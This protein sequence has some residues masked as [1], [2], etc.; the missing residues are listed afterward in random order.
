MIL[1]GWRIKL[2]IKENIV[3]NVIV[4]AKI[5]DTCLDRA[6]TAYAERA[7]TAEEKHYQ[8]SLYGKQKMVKDAGIIKQCVHLVGKTGS[9][10]LKR[11][12][13]KIA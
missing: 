4:V 8:I 1:F 6:K 11:K 9:I 5:E 10:V 13:I 3:D 12:Y 2:K 7:A